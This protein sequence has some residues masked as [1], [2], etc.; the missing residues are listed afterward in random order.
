MRGSRFHAFNNDVRVMGTLLK[1]PPFTSLGIELMLPGRRNHGRGGGRRGHTPPPLPFEKVPIY[2][3]SVPATFP[4]P[5][6]WLGPNPI[7]SGPHSL[8]VSPPPP[9]H[10]LFKSFRRHCHDSLKFFSWQRGTEGQ[11]QPPSAN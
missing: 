5:G 9:T 3:P 7:R 6:P 10:T 4:H 11:G 8:V 1:L 2:T